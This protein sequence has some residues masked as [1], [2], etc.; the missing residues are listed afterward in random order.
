MTACLPEELFIRTDRTYAR[1]VDIPEGIKIRLSSL[2][3]TQYTHM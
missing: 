2:V 1:F 3:R